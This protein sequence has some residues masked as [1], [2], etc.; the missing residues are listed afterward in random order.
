MTNRTGSSFFHATLGSTEF[1]CFRDLIS[2]DL[3]YFWYFEFCPI[4]PDADLFYARLM[5][6]AKFMTDFDYV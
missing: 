6:E 1:D 3:K 4:E 5:L 2:F